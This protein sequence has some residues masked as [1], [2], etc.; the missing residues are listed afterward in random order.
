MR[1]VRCLVRQRAAAASR[2]W[3]GVLRVFRGEQRSKN[4][5]GREVIPFTIVNQSGSR[6]PAYIYMQGN[7]NAVEPAFNTYYLSN[8]NGDCTRFSPNAEIKTYG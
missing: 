6:E 7:T 1:T 3:N 5:I 2:A 8:F 4:N